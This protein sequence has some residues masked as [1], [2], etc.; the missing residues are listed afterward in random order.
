MNGIAVSTDVMHCGDAL[1][2]EK[3]VG[4]TLI[5]SFGGMRFRIMRF[6]TRV[7]RMFPSAP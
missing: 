7:C 3:P 1:F 6:C 2:I 5:R 4:R